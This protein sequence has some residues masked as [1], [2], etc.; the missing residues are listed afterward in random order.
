[1]IRP[2]VGSLRRLALMGLAVPVLL[3]ITFWLFLPYDNHLILFIRFWSQK[4]G[5][6]MH[7]PFRDDSWLFEPPKF[8]VDLSS[9]VALIIK[10]GYGTQARV[11]A[12]LDA[13]GLTGRETGAEAV[14]II[15]DFTKPPTQDR[16]DGRDYVIHDMIAAALDSAAL[17]ASAN[18]ER[19][20]KYR[21]L[22]AAI[23]GNR[24][25]EAREIS[26]SVG[27][28]LDAMKVSGKPPELPVLMKQRRV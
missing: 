6:F 2:R 20:D 28:E 9:D 17:G 14:L 11:P 16:G 25:G 7:K 18:S 15:G 4:L 22:A 13:L 19:L 26:K 24:D 27:W 10:T 1:M 23:Q 21:S 12:Q 3:T 8:P 5:I